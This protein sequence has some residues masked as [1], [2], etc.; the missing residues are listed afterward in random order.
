MEQEHKC[1]SCGMEM[2]FGYVRYHTLLGYERKLLI[3]ECAYDTCSGQDFT[4]HE[5][6]VMELDKRIEELEEQL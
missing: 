2:D 6:E 5:L 3:Y 4:E 1:P